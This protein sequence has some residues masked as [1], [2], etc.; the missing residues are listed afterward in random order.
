MY[1][2]VWVENK[3][4]MCGGGYVWVGSKGKQGQKCLERQEKGAG[5]PPKAFKQRSDNVTP[6][7]GYFGCCMENG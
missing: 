6:W 7:V 1:Q 3:L 4:S 5:K 2:K